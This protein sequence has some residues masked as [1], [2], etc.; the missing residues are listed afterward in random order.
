MDSFARTLF[1]DRC[2]QWQLGPFGTDWRCLK[3]RKHDGDHLYEPD[4]WGNH[5]FAAIWTTVDHPSARIDGSIS[6][7]G[8]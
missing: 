2:H 4:C 6:E 5:D 1:P 3:Y 7:E 8:S